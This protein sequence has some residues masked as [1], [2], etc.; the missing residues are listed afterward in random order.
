MSDTVYLKGL[1]WDHPRAWQGL[2]AETDRLNKSQSDVFLSWDKHSLRG[3]ESTPIAETAARYDLIILDHPF[4]GDAAQ[5][6]SLMNLQDHADILNFSTLTKDYAGPSFES[7][8]YGGGHWALPIDAAC[9][10]AALRADLMD[11]PIPRSFDD[12]ISFGIAGGLGLSMANPHA[13]MNFMTIAGR[14]GADLN[15]TGDR[16]LPEDIALR[17]F[18]ILRKIARQIPHEAFDWSSID[19][20]DAMASENR[21]SYCPMVFC[22]NSYAQAAA[23]D[24]HVLQFSPLPG[25]TAEQHPGGSVAGGAGLAISACTPNPGE[26][27]KVLKH[28]VSQDAQVRMALDGGQPAHS[29]VW[30]TNA[31]NTINNEFFNEC[32]PDMETASLRPRHAG[33][34]KLQNDAGALLRDDAMKQNAPSLNVILQLEE[35]FQSSKALT[36]RPAERIN[37]NH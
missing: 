3:F 37:G 8:D 26:A 10:T 23:T 27:L 12:V 29:A 20:L 22:F 34:M 32:R 28:L 33:Y 25:V 18:D 31:P 6:G 16:L 9:Q 11:G 1:T 24:K 15:G 36:Q 2:F 21:V 35:M 19:L 30:K 5:D 14:H 17:S 7:Y 4:A 13:F